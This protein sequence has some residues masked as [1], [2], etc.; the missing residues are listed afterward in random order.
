MEVKRKSGIVKIDLKS[1]VEKLQL[2]DDTSLEM[3]LKVSGGKTVRPYEVIESVLGLKRDEA[4]KVSELKTKVH[5][6]MG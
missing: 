4:K 2:R 1:W 6:K 5:F 3:A